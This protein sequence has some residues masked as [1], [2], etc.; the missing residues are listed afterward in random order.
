M[1][2]QDENTIALNKMLINLDVDIM[3]RGAYNEDNELVEYNVFNGTARRNNSL[4]STIS[5]ALGVNTTAKLLD[6]PNSVKE[7]IVLARKMDLMGEQK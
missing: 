3:V 2:R 5:D 1:Y 6:S 4:Y 7:A